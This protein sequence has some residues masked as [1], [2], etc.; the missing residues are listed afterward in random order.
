MRKIERYYLRQV[1]SV[2]LIISLIIVSI[3]SLLTASKEYTKISH[4]YTLQ[5]CSKY[6]L[7]EAVGL[8]IEIAPI[9]LFLSIV[10][11]HWQ[12][13]QKSLWISAALSGQSDKRWIGTGVSL[14]LFT[15]STLTILRYGFWSNMAFEASKNRLLALEK[16]SSPTSQLDKIEPIGD[17]LLYHDPRGGLS[18]F[19]MQQQKIISEQEQDQLV[20]QH[21]Y[22][23]E[24]KEDLAVSLSALPLKKK[25][26]YKNVATGKER[27]LLRGS[28]LKE[29]FYPIILITAVILGWRASPIQW[30]NRKIRL[31][32]LKI[33]ADLAILY[34]CLKLIPLAVLFFKPSTVIWGGLALLMGAIAFPSVKES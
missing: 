29:F 32:A 27:N 21:R 23:F 3:E 1:I 5:L 26:D 33:T 20:E 18:L 13:G 12:W 17:Y 31:S 34:L 30:N 6:L 2:W 10:M 25:I 7:S 4:A 24:R 8:F 11:V 22:F 28:L 14:I 9:A 16:L 15:L 19:D